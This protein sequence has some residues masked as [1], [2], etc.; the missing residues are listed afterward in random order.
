MTWSIL[1]TTDM[2]SPKDVHRRVSGSA[3]SC[4]SFGNQSF[5]ISYFKT[6]LRCKFNN[7]FMNHQGPPRLPICS[8]AD[9]LTDTWW[10]SWYTAPWRCF[11]RGT[12]FPDVR[13]SAKARGFVVGPADFPQKTCFSSH[14]FKKVVCSLVSMLP[15]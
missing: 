5:L 12:A 2:A 11:P 10:S 8:P 1:G 6:A 4:C 13:V 3:S 15:I 9:N 7:K 14:M